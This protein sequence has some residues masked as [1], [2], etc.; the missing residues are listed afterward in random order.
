MRAI[1]TTARPLRG[2]GPLLQVANPIHTL[3]NPNTSSSLTVMMGG[4]G[5]PLS[6]S[7]CER[8]S[9]VRRTTT[10]CRSAPCARYPQRQA[11]SRAW[12]APTGGSAGAL[13][14]VPMFRQLLP[15]GQS[16]PHPS[17][18]EYQFFVD[19]DDGRNGF[20]AKRLTLRAHFARPSHDYDL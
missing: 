14:R 17:E 19:G 11:S 12:P 16:N 3:R 2:H 10:I 8:T 7:P 4:M 20:A 15:G 6:D 13:V 18:S 1:S 9:R 5:S